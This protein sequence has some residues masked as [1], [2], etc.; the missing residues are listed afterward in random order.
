MARL[1]EGVADFAK[2]GNPRACRGWG[3][4]VESST[5]YAAHWLRMLG[6]TV[7]GHA[8]IMVVAEDAAPPDD[9]V[10]VIR[11]W[12]FQVGRAGSGLLASAIAGASTVIGLPGGPSGAL[13]A[14][15][16][17]KWCGLYGAILAL[18][19][20][21]RQKP[22]PGR[23]PIAYDVSGADVLRA[24]ALQNA[25]SREEMETLWRRN[26]RIPVQHGGIFPM[27]FFAC[28]DGY[29]ALLGRSKR[30]WACI[31]NALDDPIWA[32]GDEYADPFEI[33]RNSEQADRL[34]VETLAQF[35]RDEPLQR[36][37]DHGAVIAPVFTEA[38]ARMRNVFRRDYDT[39]CGPGLPFLVSHPRGTGTAAM[40]DGARANDA[41][42]IKRAGRTQNGGPSRSL[43][44]AGLRCLELC[45]VWSG[46]MVGQ[47][48]A[49][50]GAEVV[51]IESHG[52]FDLYRTRGL[53]AR[54]G[55]MPEGVRIESSVYFHSL[56]RNKVGMTLDLKD[57][58]GL[59]IMQR[60][61]SESDVLLDNFTVGTLD[62]LGLTQ[63]AMWQANPNLTVLS[64]S[65][66][67]KESE[68]QALRSY[69]LVLS[70]LG[71]A[72][73]LIEI[74]GDFVGSPTYS[75]SDPNA[76]LFA[77][78]GT[79]GGALASTVDPNGVALDVSQIEAA[80]TLVGTA[81]P[82]LGHTYT[83]VFADDGT[84][85]AL[86]VPPTVE[87]GELRGAL[88]GEAA[89]SIPSRCAA[90]GVA[91]APV[92]ELTATDSAAVFDCDGWI[93]AA[94]PNTGAERI[95]AAPWRV[96]GR[97]PGVAKPAPRLGEGN[98]YVLRRAVCPAKAG[99]FSGS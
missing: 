29:V 99:L 97:R 43:P 76:A 78:L 16:P 73:A 86:S 61:I 8:P 51:K 39:E 13:P 95:V 92:L 56:N 35:T 74:D 7:T 30:D 11:L 5:H 79:L 96:D 10:C 2:A 90:L 37:L 63:E 33:A 22:L 36:G 72:E 46:P 6:A 38:E 68:L 75:L 1:H 87:V 14:D 9:A 50:L 69:G 4:G 42:R 28:R 48:L 41:A 85:F 66:P 55:E 32:E 40:D 67:G 3:P 60:L 24:F 21:W 58:R 26:G 98:D 83:V 15:V 12:D 54:R 31:R 45:W 88:T 70:A 57:G 53:E 23:A 44:L 64:M 47:T 62:R 25:G 34:L 65:G 52:R 27:G 94:H 20:T 18:A 82:A 91:C 59:D 93:D 80:G 71:G 19:E 84:E 49:D 77:T 81:T 89:R 17:E